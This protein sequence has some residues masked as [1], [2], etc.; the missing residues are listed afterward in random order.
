LSFV[1]ILMFLGLLILG[2]LGL[3]MTVCGG[4]FLVFALLNL[5][6]GVEMLL[7]IA[8]GSFVVG[9]GLL[10]AAVTRFQRSDD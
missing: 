4:G 8:L 7:I 6:R 10:F 9:L 1:R 3:A 2:L 5:R